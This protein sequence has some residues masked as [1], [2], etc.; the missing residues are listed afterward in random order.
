MRQISNYRKDL[1]SSTRLLHLLSSRVAR[2]DQ[3]L[4]HLNKM[5][6]SK[7]ADKDANQLQKLLFEREQ[8]RL[9]ELKLSTLERLAEAKHLK[10]YANTRRQRIKQLL[11]DTV[12]AEGYLVKFDEFCDKLVD[13]VFTQEE[14][15]TMIKIFERQ[16]SSLR[17]LFHSVPVSIL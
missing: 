4:I 13:V 8:E 12:L 2:C 15:K 1:D 6:E 5:A 3:Q 16:R 11:A 10:V 17:I 9:Q 7:M 14:V